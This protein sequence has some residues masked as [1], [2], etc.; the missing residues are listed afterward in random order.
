MFRIRLALVIAV[1]FSFVLLL[2]AVMYWGSNQV[3]G[4]FQRSQAAYEAFER[5][6]RLSQKPTV[7]SNKMD[8]PI[9]GGP[10]A[11]AGVETRQSLFDGA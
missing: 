10:N 3:I 2:G 11:K 7:I 6:E 4:H 8:R 5:Y 9:T 1:S